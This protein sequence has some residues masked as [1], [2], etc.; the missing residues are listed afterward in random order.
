M[1]GGL[2]KALIA[3]LV[4]VPLLTSCSRD[5]APATTVATVLDAPRALPAVALIGKDGQ[6]FSVAGLAGR[7]TLVFF[8]FTHC[9][10]ICPLTLVVLAEALESLREVTARIRAWEAANYDDGDPMVP[11]LT[12]SGLLDVKARQAWLREAR[13]KTGK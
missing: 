9:P 7:P 3:A 11:L 13:R 6:P 4:A 8:G 5:A 1:I 10:D 12:R 2:N